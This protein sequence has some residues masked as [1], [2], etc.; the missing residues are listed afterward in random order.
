[1]LKKPAFLLIE[2]IVSITIFSI[3]AFSFLY[4]SSTYSV[5]NNECKRRNFA[6]ESTINFAEEGVL[7]LG[8]QVKDVTN[9]IIELN[10]DLKKFI[11]DNKQIPNFK[12]L[13]A[14]RVYT[15]SKDRKCNKQ[16]F[17]NVSFLR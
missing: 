16:N 11:I 12:G 13:Q 10:S 15:I 9:E 6:T 2:L 8:I 5:A 3:C 1:M 14:F 7:N 17:L 4:L